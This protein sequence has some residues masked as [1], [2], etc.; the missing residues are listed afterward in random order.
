M[1]IVSGPDNSGKTS[2]LDYL[3]SEVGLKKMPKC[4]FTPVWEHPEE[5]TKWVL[6]TLKGGKFDIVDRCYIDELVYGPIMRGK[7]MFDYSDVISINQ[8]LVESKPLLIICNPGKEKILETYYE[9]EQ[10]PSIDRNMFVKRRFYEILGFYDFD[11]IPVYI[12][13]YRFDPDYKLVTKVVDFYSIRKG[14]EYEYK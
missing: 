6:Q 12:F 10:Y 4:E 2:L 13:N 14:T 7:I 8:Q 5:Y 9:R 3:V 11:E 1:I